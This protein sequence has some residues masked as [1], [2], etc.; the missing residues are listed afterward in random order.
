MVR[1]EVGG[2]PTE[3]T[4]YASDHSHNLFLPFRDA[5][6]GKEPYGAGRCLDLDAH[7]DEVLVDSSRLE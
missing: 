1:F 3:V 2:R 6:S 7:G 5:T 4:L